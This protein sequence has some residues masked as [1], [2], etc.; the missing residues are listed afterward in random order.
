MASAVARKYSADIDPEHT[1]EPGEYEGIA[2]SADVILDIHL[3][4]GG[5][6]VH[7]LVNP[8]GTTIAKVLLC[9][10]GGSSLRDCCRGQDGTLPHAYDVT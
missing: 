9:G 4:S 3:L 6:L 7:F 10:S 1:P 5:D 8:H 2:K